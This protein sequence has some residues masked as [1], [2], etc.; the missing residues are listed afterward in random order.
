MK[1]LLL[2]LMHGL[3]MAGAFAGTGAPGQLPETRSMVQRE[4]PPLFMK[5]LL[6]MSDPRGLS[7]FSHGLEPVRDRFCIEDTARALVA[8]LK[9]HALVPDEATAK[10]AGQYLQAMARLQQTGGLFHF[11]YQKDGGFIPRL[12][13]GDA[14]SRALWGL[15][16]ASA[17]GIDSAMREAAQLM[18]LKALAHL[19]P[20]GPMETS[21]ALQGLHLFLKA[22]PGHVP[23]NQA[24]R[25]GADHLLRMLPA[26]EGDPW[27]WPGRMV[28]YDSARLPLALLLAHAATGDE[29]YRTAGLR[30]LG[31][32]SQT[33]FPGDGA[34]L[35]VI[36][37]RGWHPQGQPAAV[38]DQ[39]PIDP[40]GIV[41]AC[42]QAWR[43][44]ADEIWSA[45]ARTAFAWY[46][47]HNS[48]H[49][50]MYDASTGSCRDAL[51][52]GGTNPNCGGEA[53]VSYLIART[54]MESLTVPRVP[55]A[56]SGKP[57]SQ[58]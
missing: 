37:N 26:A 12:A 28:T 45:R 55:P 57:G 15:G 7:E 16:H 22:Q 17:Y 38:A 19:Q 18:F 3:A 31:F 43:L 6:A 1:I 24:L 30:V 29:R 50:P 58:N 40:S 56:S 13:D 39:Q 21:Y 47:G 5:H 14:F 48:A 33:N 54:E 49:Q 27:Q 11:G 4:L 8:V 41:E 10:P 36:G 42:V 46:T 32:L 44:T 34:M 51:S 25:A 52:P 35:Q 20:G 53:I 9:V 2:F 23:A